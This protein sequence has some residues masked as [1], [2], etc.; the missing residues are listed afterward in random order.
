MQGMGKFAVI[1]P[2]F[3]VKFCDEQITSPYQELKIGCPVLNTVF[4]LTKV[5]LLPC[6]DVTSREFRH[7]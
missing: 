6:V 7:F 4:V 3:I 2:I 1:N 5:S